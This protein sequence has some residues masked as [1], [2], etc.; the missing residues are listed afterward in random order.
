MF[1]DAHVH[2][3]ELFRG[4]KDLGDKEWLADSVASHHLA[5]DYEYF[6]E[7]S[8]NEVVSHYTLRAEDIISP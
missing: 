5:T 7:V 2:V 4:E 3:G 6:N 1:S 8:P